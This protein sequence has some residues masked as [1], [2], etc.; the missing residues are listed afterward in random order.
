MN[1]P[2]RRT[3]PRDEPVLCCPICGEECG[4]YYRHALTRVVVGCDVCLEPYDP[5]EG[6]P[7]NR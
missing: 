6:A 1:E 3:E 4:H 7:W 5:R 2:E